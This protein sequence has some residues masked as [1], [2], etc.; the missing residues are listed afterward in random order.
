MP[1]RVAVGRALLAME[2]ADKDLRKLM[3]RAEHRLRRAAAG[4]GE[5]KVVA[6]DIEEAL[7][8]FLKRKGLP[9]GQDDYLFDFEGRER[10]RGV[11]QVH[12]Y[13]LLGTW[14][15]PDAAVLRPFALAIEFDREHETGRS[16]FKT[17][18]MKT[19]CHV[20]SGAYDAAVQVLVVRQSGSS[21]DVYGDDGS[22]YTGRLLDVLRAHGV[23]T[24]F[25]R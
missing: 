15:H 2:S 20:M 14:T 13:E 1:G 9:A 11:R 21:A 25:V 6:S 22:D 10:P 18:L 16:H 23:V 24:I 12:S 3:G 17:A 19:A 4:Q 8:K 5:H 7:L